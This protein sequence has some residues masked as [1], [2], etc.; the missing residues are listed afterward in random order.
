M[1][2]DSPCCITLTVMCWCKEST[3]PMMYLWVP[4]SAATSPLQKS[5]E[6]CDG[7][8]GC[9]WP[10]SLV[11]SAVLQAR[12]LNVRPG[13]SAAEGLNDLFLNNTKEDCAWWSSRPPSCHRVH[14][15]RMEQVTWNAHGAEPASPTSPGSFLMLHP[16]LQRLP[17]EGHTHCVF[18]YSHCQRLTY[19]VQQAAASRVPSLSHL[20]NPER[21]FNC[22]KRRFVERGVPDIS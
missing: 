12:C 15:R 11:Y 20:P 16:A 1:R 4:P 14:V 22:G 21:F 7:R 8:E 6:N 13:L 18:A 10:E 3:W 19:R 17:D 2:S 9:S 5:V